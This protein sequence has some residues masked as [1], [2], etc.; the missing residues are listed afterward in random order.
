MYAGD[1]PGDPA[2]RLHNILVAAKHS[3]HG[4][5]TLLTGWARFFGLGPNENGESEALRQ[6]SLVRQLVPEIERRMGDIDD[7]GH[8]REKF[9]GWRGNVKKV[10]YERNLAQ[11]YGSLIGQLDDNALTLL[12]VCSREIS[13]SGCISDISNEELSWILN[14]CGHLVSAVNA[15]DLDPRVRELIM[16]HI[17]IIER[18]VMDCR[19]IGAK[20]LRKG[21]EQGTGVCVTTPVELNDEVRKS[22]VYD[23]FIGILMKFERV[24]KS[25]NESFKLFEYVTKF[26]LSGPG[27]GAV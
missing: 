14:E 3:K 7:L 9:L 24:T 18:A 23:Q 21:L 13:R 19:I 2:L 16:Y 6:L 27:P 5:D 26:F 8:R 1:V 12:D 4:G 25:A 22:S 10:L 20:A 17:D 15:A 11:T